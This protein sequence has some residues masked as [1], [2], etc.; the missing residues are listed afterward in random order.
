MINLGNLDRL[1]QKK[2]LAISEVS[3][4]YG[5]PE[6]SV[7][8]WMMQPCGVISLVLDIEEKRRMTFED[9]RR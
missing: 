7:E 8:F 1:W 4:E 5:Y 2:I 9:L 3:I 6:Q